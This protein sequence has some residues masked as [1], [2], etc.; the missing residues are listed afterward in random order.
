MLKCVLCGLALGACGMF[1]PVAL[2]SGEEQIAQVAAGWGAAAPAALLA[3]GAAK[4]VLTPLCLEMGWRGGHFFPCIFM[5]VAAGY[6][7]ADLG[8]AD[9]VFCAAVVSG[10]FLAATT[11]RPLLSAALLLLCFPLRAVPWMLAAAF[12]GSRLPVPGQPRPEK[13]PPRTDRRGPSRLRCA[14]RPK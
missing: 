6:G 5:G 9:P 2:F 14:K 13:R 10:A 7:L 11:R 8:G 3:A 4:A 12:I 1:L